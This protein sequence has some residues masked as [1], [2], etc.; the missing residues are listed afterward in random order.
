MIA[1]KNVTRDILNLKYIIEYQECDITDQTTKENTIE[2]P[3]AGSV[4]SGE[5]SALAKD[6]FKHLESFYDKTSLFVAKKLFAEGNDSAAVINYIRDHAPKEDIINIDENKRP[7]ATVQVIDNIEPIAGADKIEVASILGWKIVVQKGLHK[8]GDK[9]VY[10]EVDSCLPIKPEYEF[11]RKSSLR[12]HLN[13]TEIFRIKS[14]KL[15]GQIS[16]GLIIPLPADVEPVVDKDVTEQ[17]GIVKWITEESADLRGL[18][19]G[20]FPSFLHKTYET[21]VQG[22]RNILDE[23]K[24]VEMYISTKMDGSSGTYYKRDGVYGVCSRNLEKKESD[25]SFWKMSRKYD[26]ANRLPD[27]FAIQGEVCG[28]GIQK[29]RLALTDHELYVFNVFDIKSNSY[30]DMQDFLDFC[31]EFGFTT[32][33]IEEVFTFDH[34]L[35]WLLE[36]AKGTYPNTNNPKEGI[37]L[38]PT[39]E[40]Y[41]DS[42]H[43]RLSF[44]VLNNDFLLAE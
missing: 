16:Q 27:N 5:F 26:I 3:F 22:L 40:R 15:R 29:N 28:P 12:K 37:V 41:S 30:L 10:C 8:V 39:K 18:N 25:C 23:I 32:V 9:V 4:E 13:G 6:Y 44:K 14:C 24:G 17:L 21:R 1:I 2:I 31:K 34:D 20:R 19:K 43:G 42:L 35:N 7:L 33:P 36:R 11:L 38:R